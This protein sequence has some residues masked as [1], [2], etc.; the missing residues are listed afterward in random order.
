MSVS[1]RPDLS[2]SEQNETVLQPAVPGNH[3]LKDSCRVVGMK[4]ALVLLLMG[5]LAVGNE[6]L[7][8]FVLIIISNKY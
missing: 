6:H 2:L 3:S 1:S 8:V 5:L 4:T 7:L